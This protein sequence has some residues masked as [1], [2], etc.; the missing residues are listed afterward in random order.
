MIYEREWVAFLTALFGGRFG[1]GGRRREGGRKRS[2]GLR[3]A[4]ERKGRVG[5]SDS[6]FRVSVLTRCG[7]DIDP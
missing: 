4:A 1:G 2:Q 7:G 3:M 6:W 5:M